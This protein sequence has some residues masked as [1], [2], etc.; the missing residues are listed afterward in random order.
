MLIRS[1]KPINW[2][3]IKAKIESSLLVN[4]LSLVLCCGSGLISHTQD[5]NDMHKVS[6]SSVDVFVA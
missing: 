3:V 6:R 4:V 5:E 1:G 2:I